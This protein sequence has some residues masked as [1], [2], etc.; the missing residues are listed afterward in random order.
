MDLVNISYKMDNQFDEGECLNFLKN[1]GFES[2]DLTNKYQKFR[3]KNIGLTV[4]F[5][6]S[7]IHVQGKLNSESEIFLKNLYQS[8]ALYLDKKNQ[9]Q[10][11]SL[12][13]HTHNSIV[14]TECNKDSIFEINGKIKENELSF[15]LDCGHNLKRNFAFCMVNSRILPD[16]SVL[17]G[18]I[19]SK[20]IE[21]GHFNNFEI[22][23]PT[24]ILDVVDALHKG[25]K[26]KGVSSEIDRLRDLERQNKISIFN[27]P[28]ANPIKDEGTLDAEEDLIIIK[29]ANLTN[30]VIFTGDRIMKTRAVLKHRP[31]IFLDPNLSSDLKNMIK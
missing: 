27:C 6:D 31:T 26:K 13:G 9:S 18:G 23:I 15:I 11:E 20:C 17:F 1:S 2:I 14:C 10:F 28:Y 4:T 25:K 8:K 12:F 21:Y 30:S 22:V 29:I 24:F 5:Y 16:I 3:F 7:S 19:L